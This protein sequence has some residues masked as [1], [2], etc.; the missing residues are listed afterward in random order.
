MMNFNFN[1]ASAKASL[2]YLK[3]PW[4]ASWVL[5]GLLAIF[6]P[7]ITW[8]VQRGAYY[9]A[10]GY[11]MELE[12]KQRQYYEN[13]EEN[14]NNNQ[15][16]YYNYYKECSW[17]N[18]PCRKRQYYLASM[19]DRNDQDGNQQTLPG[20]FIF[21]GGADNS[22]NM[23][24]WRE[25]NT[26]VRASTVTPSGLKFVYTWTLFMF[27]G[28]YVYGTFSLA[29]KH[30]VSNLVTLLGVSASLGLM[31]MIMAVQGIISNDDRDMEDSYYGWYGQI[32]V[33][34]TYT[35]F[36]IMIFS[37]G[38][39]SAFGVQSY[40]NKRAQTADQEV[41]EDSNENGGDYKEYDAP[42]VA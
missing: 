18:W 38:F 5:S 29:K 12:E 30:S 9:D 34:M 26:G 1:L 23:Q 2:V 21:F 3:D 14:N 10:Y 8:S 13:Q 16:N 11:A 42:V 41:N 25:E 32:G 17:F 15:N 24:R 22:E 36:W 4:T 35:Y 6:I 7:V 33:L 19:D 37:I 31:N 39:L 40:L 28:L 27:I 20:W